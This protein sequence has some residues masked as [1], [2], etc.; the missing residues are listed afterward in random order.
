[1]S[2]QC[3]S[4]ETSIKER[5]PKEMTSLHVQIHISTCWTHLKIHLGL[6]IVKCHADELLNICPYT[7]MTN[8]VDNPDLLN[9]ELQ[10][11]YV[12]RPAFGG[13][14]HWVLNRGSRLVWWILFPDLK[15]TL[16]LLFQFLQL[17]LVCRNGKEKVL[18]N[19]HLI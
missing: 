16:T 14:R 2:Q 9:C 10:R 18:W 19:V 8:I 1:M 13:G 15:L 12:I 17:I 4:S 11:T 3:R 5:L 7:Y 6:I